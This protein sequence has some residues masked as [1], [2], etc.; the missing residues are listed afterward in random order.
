MPRIVMLSKACIIGAYQRKLEEIAALAPELSLTVA[1]PPRWGDTPLERAHVRGYRLDV[2][3]LWFNGHFHLHCYPTL[4]RLLRELQPDLVHIDEEPYNLATYHALRLARR[5][6]ARTLWF[7]WQN[8]ARRY[9]PPF[10]HMERYA[11]RHADH[12]I[13]GSR[14]AAEVWRGKG[15]RGPLSV[16]PQFGVDPDIFAPPAAPRAAE[17]LHIAYVGRL[18]PEKGVDVLLDA[19]H[20]L[21]GAWHATILGHGSEAASLQAQADALGLADRVAFQSARPSVEMPRFYK[22]V[23]VLVLPSRARPNWMEQFGRVLIEAMACGAVA[24]GAE[25]GEIP[26]V[27]GDAGR[28][29]AEDDAAGLRAI[30]D[31][32]RAHPETRRALAEAGRARVL[33]H[34]TQRHIAQE[35][36][37]VYRAVLNREPPA[38]KRAEL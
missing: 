15:Y 12:A 26:H 37:R 5:H 2:V 24:V 1:V 19:L 34:F 22:S 17:S 35:T 30:L 9:P 31:A 3:P 6:K 33:R 25:S 27:I 10:A 7:S 20:G 38:A 32:L 21:P 11:M 36:V 23:D 4:N 13:V 8:L 29:F 18:V 28:T 16:I 14:A